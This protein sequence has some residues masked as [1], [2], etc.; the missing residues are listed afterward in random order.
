MKHVYVNYEDYC[1]SK[2][3]KWFVY[4]THKNQ[5]HNVWVLMKCELH[6]THQMLVS[7]DYQV[8]FQSY[9]TYL[10]TRSPLRELHAFHCLSSHVTLALASILR[11]REYA[12]AILSILYVNN[13][14]K[15][16]SMYPISDSCLS[17]IRMSFWWLF[18]SLSLLISFGLVYFDRYLRGYCSC[19]FYTFA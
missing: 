16:E 18:L 12:P 17:N 7:A 9:L 13:Q 8:T 10:F 15:E 2:G 1:S 19:S 14:S 5:A 4:L 11:K 3:S 6:K